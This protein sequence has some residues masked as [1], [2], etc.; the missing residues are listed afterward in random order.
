MLAYIDS[1]V[2]L[3]FILTEAERLKEFK[4]VEYAVSSK[5]LQVECLRTIDRYKIGMNI[6]DEQIAKVISKLYES[7]EHIELI[8]MTD[9][10]LERAS[11]PFP[12]S[13]A[14]LDAIHLAS[15][16][17]WK[18]NFSKNI[19]MMTHDKELGQA[20]RSIGFEVLGC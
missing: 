10:I 17:E 9:I 15:L 4:K 2:L 20:S 19:I 6:P 7:L 16:I 14:T 8:P 12:T 18:A 3:R 11:Q 5:L 13:L 1:S